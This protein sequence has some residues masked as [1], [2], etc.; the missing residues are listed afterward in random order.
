MLAIST[1]SIPEIT[2]CG[3]DLIF[4]IPVTI[5][6]TVAIFL[7]MFLHFGTEPNYALNS[8]SCYSFSRKAFQV[9]I[10]PLKN[11]REKNRIFFPSGPGHRLLPA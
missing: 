10:S 2:S 1:L 3:K 6:V 5:L 4:L 8:S 11:Y 9:V 7:Q